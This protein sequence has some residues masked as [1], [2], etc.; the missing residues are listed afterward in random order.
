MIFKKINKIIIYILFISLSLNL[1]ISPNITSKYTNNSKTIFVDDDNINGPFTG[2]IH[3]PYKT[4]EEAINYADDLDTVFVFSGVYYENIIITK[5]ISLIGENKYTTIIDG[6]YKE[7][8]IQIFNDNIELSG[9]T[10]RNSGYDFVNFFSGIKIYSNNV[11]INQNIIINNF[12]GIRISYSYKSKITDNYIVNNIKDGISVHN[13]GNL[14]LIRNI[15]DANGRDGFFISKSSDGIIYNNTL[16]NQNSSG[17]EFIQSQNNDINYN[18]LSD[19]HQ[20]GI[21]L[22]YNCPDN[23]IV[24]NNI[25]NNDKGLHL[26]ESQNN[27]I[28]Y[29]NFINNKNV[30]AYLE[31]C[32]F[33]PDGNIFRSN[34]WDDCVNNLPKPIHGV[35]KLFD[36]TIPWIQF[37]WR[38]A[39]EPYD[40]I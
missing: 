28:F 32:K 36:L 13:C 27:L 19:N 17:I 25:K 35:N 1:I 12:D 22:N 33:Y 14:E 18:I 37:D 31:N 39:T 8:V 30:N 20:Y 11:K 3:Y 2:T 40:I 15:V 4:I 5:T 34:Y 16:I 10:I 38:P 6:N 21:L 9:F 23:T 24:S 29:N 26:Y 7:D